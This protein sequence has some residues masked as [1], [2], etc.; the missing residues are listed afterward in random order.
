[1]T[2]C[3]CRQTNPAPPPTLRRAHRRD[4]ARAMPAS[5]WSTACRTE[6]C[7]RA[8]AHRSAN[9]E[10]G[11]RYG[12]TGSSS[13][14]YR[15]ALRGAADIDQM[16]VRMRGEPP[17]AHFRKRQREPFDRILGRGD[18]RRRHLWE[19]LALQHF[20]VG[21]RHASVEFDVALFLQFVFEAGK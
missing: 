5:H 19:V 21:H 20:T 1:M 9:A 14:I 8:F 6:T 17:R 2:R 4:R 10:N 13:P 15:A 7:S 3:A 12:C 18:F 11:G 16:T